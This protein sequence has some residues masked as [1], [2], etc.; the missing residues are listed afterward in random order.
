MSEENGS[1]DDQVPNLIVVSLPN[2]PG[3]SRQLVF[4][5]LDP[6][7]GEHTAMRHLRIRDQPAPL[8]QDP[9]LICLGQRVWTFPW[10]HLAGGHLEIIVVEGIGRG[11]LQAFPPSFLFGTLYISIY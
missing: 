9:L 4:V 3:F 8:L 5:H 1:C 2:A 6:L 7:L 10:E 11:V